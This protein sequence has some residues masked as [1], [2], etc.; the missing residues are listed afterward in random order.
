[1][2]Q[3]WIAGGRVTRAE[4]VS[5]WN[6]PEK[7]F[8]PLRKGTVLGKGDVL[9]VPSRGRLNVEVGTESIQTPDGGLP[10]TMDKHGGWL[11]HVEGNPPAPGQDVALEEAKDPLH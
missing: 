9:Q 5:I 1:M 11:L 3:S 7:K 2:F 4:G 8:E 6:Q 10:P